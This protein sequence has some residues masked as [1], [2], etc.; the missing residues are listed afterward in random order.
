[1]S[2]FFLGKKP[3]KM[4]VCFHLIWEFPNEQKP[5]SCFRCIKIERSPFKALLITLCGTKISPPKAFLEF[6]CFLVPWRLNA[7][8]KNVRFGNDFIKGKFWV[9]SLAVVPQISLPHIALYNHSILHYRHGI[10]WIC[11]SGPASQPKLLNFKGC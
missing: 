10:R 3:L 1:M 5:C 9:P 4:D 6:R 7:N 8:R 2:S 11:I